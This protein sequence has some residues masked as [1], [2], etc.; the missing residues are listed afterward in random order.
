MD[1]M[2]IKH[3]EVFAKHGVKPEEKALGQKFLLSATLYIDLRD[4]GKSDDV[5]K[6]LDYSRICRDIKEFVEGNSFNLIEAIAEGLAEMLLIK[7]AEHT[8]LKTIR[9]EV[10]KPWAPVALHLDTV[11]VEIERGWHSAYIALGSNIGDREAY[12]RYAVDEIIKMDCFRSVKISGFTNTKPYGVVD[13]DDFLNGCMALET[14]LTPHELLQALQE[15]EKGAGR[16]R[17]ERWGPRT[18]D[19]D[20]VFYDDIVMADESLRIPHAQMHKREF[21]LAPLCEI[22]P[23]MLHPVLKKTVAELLDELKA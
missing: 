21:V 22:A 12:L 15:I 16:V 14:L 11:S 2:S 3:L 6:T 8:R 10:M 1:K 17:A 5:A 18:L 23:D 4:A 20:I 7:Y 9:L 19:L 13:Q